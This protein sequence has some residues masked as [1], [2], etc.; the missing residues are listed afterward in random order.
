MFLN[1]Y[2][3]GVPFVDVCAVPPNSSLGT[4]LMVIGARFGVSGKVVWFD[5]LLSLCPSPPLGM[6]E[7]G[8]CFGIRDPWNE[9][10]GYL[11]LTATRSRGFYEAA[12]LRE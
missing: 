3:T 2:F 8:L 7:R 12:V 10:D 4:V 1:M 9:F 6:E 5:G 11:R